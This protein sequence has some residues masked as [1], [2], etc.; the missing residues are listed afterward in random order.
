VHVARVQ[1]NHQAPGVEQTDFGIRKV[2]IGHTHTTLTLPEHGRGFTADKTHK[3]HEQVQ[4]PS[5]EA[6][7]ASSFPWHIVNRRA[8]TRGLLGTKA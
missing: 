5:G 6:Q 1:E 4:A 3:E 8:A 2:A 7:R